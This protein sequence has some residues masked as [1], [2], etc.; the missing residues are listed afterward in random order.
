MK[1]N[2]AMCDFHPFGAIIHRDGA[3]FHLF[4]ALSQ[5]DGAMFHP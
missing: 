1:P 4:S 3:M 2:G 5:H